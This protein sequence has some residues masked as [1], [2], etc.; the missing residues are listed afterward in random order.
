MTIRRFWKATTA[1]TVGQEEA[2]D[3]RSEAFFYHS[4]IHP[5]RELGVVSTTTVVALH[6]IY[7]LTIRSLPTGIL[8]KGLRAT[9][10]SHTNLSAESTTPAF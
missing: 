2:S 4:A 6:M 5:A 7:L 9:T 1:V 3:A 8:L 10:G